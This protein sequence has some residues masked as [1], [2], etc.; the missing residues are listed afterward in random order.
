MGL[1]V[2][3]FGGTS[4]A[5]PELITRVARRV[6]ATKKEGNDVV[7]V[8]SAMGDA[9]DELESMAAKIS[10][11]PAEREMAILMITGE[12]VSAAL[13][14][15]ALNELG[16]PARAFTGWQA[17]I[18][19]DSASPLRAKI[20]RIE[21]TRIREALREGSVAVVTGY[22]GVTEDGDETALGRGGSDLSAVALACALKADACEIYTDVDG[23]YT[24]NPRLVKDARKIRAISYEEMLELASMGAQVM[25]ARSI[26]YAKK[27]GTVIHVRSSF[28]EAPG[29]VIREADTAMEAVVVRGIAYDMTEAKITVRGV[30]DRPGVAATLFNRMAQAGINVDMIVQNVSEDGITDLSFTVTRPDL[31]KAM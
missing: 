4:V 28:S 23:V 16:Q 18:V 17:G 5:T 31:K 12:R 30:T 6:L 24:T 19:T 15:I 8:V 20:R 13:L 3:K 26:E 10:V 29:T 9:T 14:A 7:V 2:M 25:Q 27:H 22:Q 21:A 1:I 11:E